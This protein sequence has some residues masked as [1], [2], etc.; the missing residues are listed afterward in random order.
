MLG[1]MTGVW[2]WGRE[3]K[4]M[5]LGGTH[6]GIQCFLHRLTKYLQN[7]SYPSYLCRNRS[8]SHFFAIVIILSTNV[9]TLSMFV[10]L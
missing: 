9:N 2:G 10:A 5:E 3:V 7:E 6:L 8:Q 1:N 4:G